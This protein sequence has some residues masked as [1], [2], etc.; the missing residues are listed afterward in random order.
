MKKCKLYLMVQSVSLSKSKLILCISIPWISEHKFSV[1]DNPQDRAGK[2]AG[3]MM[4][5][6]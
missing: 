2:E 6:R 4:L 1:I 5:N 3:M